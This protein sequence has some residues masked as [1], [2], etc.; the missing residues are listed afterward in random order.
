MKLAS[1]MSVVRLARHQ[2]ISAT[3]SRGDICP[4]R[5]LSSLCERT[6]ALRASATIAVNDGTEG[7]N[8]KEP[9]SRVAVVASPSG[10]EVHANSLS[11]HLPLPSPLSTDSKKPTPTESTPT[12]PLPSAKEYRKLRNRH[13]LNHPQFQRL[14]LPHPTRKSL[15]HRP[16]PTMLHSMPHFWL[17]VCPPQTKSRKRRRNRWI[18]GRRN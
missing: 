3:L 7:G 12:D 10:Q 18:W 17:F 6:P 4:S 11:C 8:Q 16:T 14:S 5:P 13:P 9:A 15:I 2:D 1:H